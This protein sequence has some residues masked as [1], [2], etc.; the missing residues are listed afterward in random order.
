[1]TRLVLAEDHQIVRQGFHAL[2]E[3]AA[4]VEVVA[5]TGDGAEAVRL[6]ERLRPDVL[7]LDLGLP[8]LDGLEVARR[9]RARAPEV[10]V[11][12]LSMH[13][14][15]GY[16]A[17]AVRAGTAA[18]VLKEAGVSDLV[19]ALHAVLS[20]ER[21]FSE[22]VAPP[23][24]EPNDGAPAVTSRYETLTPRE[25]E[26]LQLVGEGLTSAQIAARLFLS[27]RTIDAHRRNILAKLDLTTPADLVRYAL[28]RGLSPG[29]A[30]PPNEPQESA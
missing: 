25:R 10:R 24:E 11:V 16:V 20:G 3:G 8:G 21:Y 7:V 4:D 18:Y 27:P 6:V 13:A 9:V 15:E 5:E 19:A 1:M 29:S 17:E 30:P 14:H 23:L 2:L 26:V 12:I 22:G 28:R